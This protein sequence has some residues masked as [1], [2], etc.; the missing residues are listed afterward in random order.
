MHSLHAQVSFVFLFIK[1][2]TEKTDRIVLVGV[3][4]LA[5]E[6][7]RGPKVCRHVCGFAPLKDGAGDHVRGLATPR[8]G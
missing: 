6:V 5:A 7:G 4:Q 3:F 2:E 1:L 8:R